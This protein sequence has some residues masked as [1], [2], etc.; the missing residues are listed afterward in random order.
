MPLALLAVLIVACGGTTSNN[1]V[2]T[3]SACESAIA[4]AAAVPEMQ[5]TVTDL[6]QAVR[7]C[8]T[9]AEFEAAATEYPAAL[10][11]ADAAMFVANRCQ[12]ERSLA[13]SSMCAAM[14]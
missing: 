7:D 9:L 12:Y 14:R 10:D 11:G 13:S 1:G 5:D 2:E 6:D 8:A 3:M 4:A